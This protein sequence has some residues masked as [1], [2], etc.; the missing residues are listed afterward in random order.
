MSE[1]I[2]TLGHGLD[3]IAYHEAAHAV[4]RRLWGFTP[5]LIRVQEH[6]EKDTVC[7]DGHVSFWSDP[8]ALQNHRC[9]AMVDIAGVLSQAMFVAKNHGG[10]SD[11]RLSPDDS[12]AIMRVFF[13][14]LDSAKPSCEIRVVDPDSGHS[15]R[16]DLAGG[17]SS[18]DFLGFRDG[19]L[20]LSRTNNLHSPEATQAAERILNWCIACLNNGWVKGRIANVVSVLKESRFNGYL[21]DSRE[22]QGLL[23]WYRD[24]SEWE[25]HLTTCEPKGNASDQ[26]ENRK[27]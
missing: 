25:E 2:L 26:I 17:Y 4:F 20:R 5:D 6:S 27:E 19:I 3:E 9:N 8:D 18:D 23:Y 21:L 7:Y 24:C 13:L 10:W 1:A 22:F 15:S 16:V 14:K 11:S 12:I